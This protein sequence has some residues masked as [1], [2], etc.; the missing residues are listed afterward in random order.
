MVVRKQFLLPVTHVVSTNPNCIT[1]RFGSSDEQLEH[2]P[3]PIALLMET[4]DARIALM[5]SENTKGMSNVDPAK[6]VLERQAQADLFRMAMER[7]AAGE[8]RWGGTLFPT[9]A[10]VQ[11]A[12]MSLEEYEDFVFAACLPEMD[13]PLEYWRRFSDR[14][15]KIVDWF[16]GKERVC[17][18]APDTDLRLSIAGRSF[19][20]CNGTRNM[21]DGEVF[22]GPVEDSVE[23]YVTLSYPTVYD[24]REVDGVRLAFEKG[25]VV[26]ATAAKNEDLLL[27]MID[28]DEGARYL[29]EFAIGTNKGITRFTGNTLFDEKID[30]SFHIALGMGF[31]TTG[32]KNQS[33]IH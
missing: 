28:T 31:P 18:L 19:I 17:V 1:G 6:M 9:N 14:Q 4:Y 15:Q 3:E 27:Q 12:E 16:V 33:A 13:D 30:D 21:P 2:V 8:F 22:T 7:E 20:N 5:G 25:R 24:G 10:H 23:G 32:S 26:K 11:D 29:G